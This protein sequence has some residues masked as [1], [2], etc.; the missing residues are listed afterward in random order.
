MLKGPQVVERSRAEARVPTSDDAHSDRD[1]LTDD[2]T[3]ITIVASDEV[4]RFIAERGGELY[5]WVSQHGWGRC[6]LALLEAVDDTG[7]HARSVFLSRA[8]ARLRSAARPRASPVAQDAGARVEQAPHEGAGLLERLGL[9]RL[10]ATQ[11]V[12][13]SRRRCAAPRAGLDGRGAGPLQQRPGPFRS[14]PS[15]R[16]ALTRRGQAQPRS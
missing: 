7:A 3:S 11:G 12:T 9:G 10:S 6:G 5:V 14:Q 16:R 2:V 4:R 1:D 8:R 13:R 15:R